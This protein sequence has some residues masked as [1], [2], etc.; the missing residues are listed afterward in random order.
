MLLFVVLL[1]L[2]L[3][4]LLLSLLS[5]SLF[6]NTCSITSTITIIFLIDCLKRYDDYDIMSIMIIYQFW[7]LYL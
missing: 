6:R 1:W 4:S 5:V 2:L 3:L 7:K